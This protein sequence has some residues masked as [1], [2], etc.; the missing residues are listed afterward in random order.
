MQRP[1]AFALSLVLCAAA[2]A[3]QEEGPLDP[4][5]ADDRVVEV[6]DHYIDVLG[7]FVGPDAGRDTRSTGYGATLIYGAHLQGPWWIEGNLFGALLETGSN[8]GSDFYQYGAG[9]DLVGTIG[10][11]QGWTPFLLAGVGGVY[12][13][14]QPD[15]RDSFNF[16]GNVGAGLVTPAITSRGLKLRAE[17][18]GLYDTFHSGQ[19]DWQASLGISIP[20]G[21]RVVERVVVREVE[22][23]QREAAPPDA[24]FDGIL[25]EF[26]QCP[27]TLAGARVDDTGCLIHGQTIILDDVHFEFDSDV[28]TQ[29]A[30][31]ILAEIAESLRFQPEI[32][33][34]VAGHT[35]HDGSHEYNDQLS[36]A[37]AA[38]VQ[39]YLTG[40][41]IE[42]ERMTARGYGERQPIATNETAE[43]RA[44]NRRVE[45]RIHGGGAR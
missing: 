3:G 34:E 29:G 15:R 31:R 5:S 36:Q 20:L 13:D 28:L 4:A 7:S 43:G 26:D 30:E 25:N 37:R 45:F 8:A 27:R 35:D 32:R 1:I 39:R 10:D 23:V 40:R 16:R 17:G 18:R 6:P 19:L 22:V 44:K 33:F 42:P 2:A 24:D 12:D 14:V 11:R 9:V 41:G 21:T 38:S